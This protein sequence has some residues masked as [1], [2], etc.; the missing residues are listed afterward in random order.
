MQRPIDSAEH[1]AKLFKGFPVV[2]MV[3]WHAA[4]YINIWNWSLLQKIVAY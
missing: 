1:R 3:A 2:V 4:W